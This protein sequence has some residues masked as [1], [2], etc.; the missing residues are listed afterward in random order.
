MTERGNRARRQPLC[1]LKTKELVA[2]FR[3]I[4]PLHSS[5]IRQFA[6]SFTEEI[7]DPPLFFRSMFGP[8]IYFQ[9]SRRIR[10]LLATGVNR[11]LGASGGELQLI[12]CFCL[13]TNRCMNLEP[14]FL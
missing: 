4:G 6:P 13:A 8:G 2:S 5:R 14:S 7:E 12:R 3:K 11:P 1:R 10:H 9:V